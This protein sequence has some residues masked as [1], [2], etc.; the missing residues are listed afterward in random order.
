LEEAQKH[1]AAAKQLRPTHITPRGQLAVIH[2]FNESYTQMEEEL[3]E[4][5]KVVPDD[6]SPYWNVARALI[7]NGKE[8]SR[9]E[10]YLKKYLDVRPEI[11]APPHAYAHWQLGL[12]YEK[13]GRKSDAVAQLQKAVALKRDFEPAQKDLRRLRG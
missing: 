1:A 8:L 13:L 5:E 11:G 12:L 3:N 10:S 6:L 9:V 4:A 2:A 7:D